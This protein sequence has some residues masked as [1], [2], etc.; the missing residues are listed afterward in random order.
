MY[1]QED[2]IGGSDYSDITLRTAPT[3]SKDR[4]VHHARMK[5]MRGY[6]L[7]VSNTRHAANF[8]M[9]GKGYEACPYHVARKM[10]REGL[11]VEGGQHTL[12]TLY[13][14][15]PHAAASPTPAPKVDDDEEPASDLDTLLAV[16]EALPAETEDLD[17]SSDDEPFEDDVF[18]DEEEA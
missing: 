4:W 7:I 18:D 3:V 11:V 10:I 16:A 1:E 13:L 2:R 17:E 5:M 9:P 8:F 6:A 14:L 15:A 12:G